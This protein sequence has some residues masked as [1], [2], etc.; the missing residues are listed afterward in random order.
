VTDLLAETLPKIPQLSHLSPIQLK[1]LENVAV[2]K[3][4]PAHN[5]L[6]DPRTASFYLV[7]IEAGYVEVLDRDGS[8]RR[9][10][11][12]GG[13]FAAQTRPNH[14]SLFGRSRTKLAFIL[15]RDIDRVLA[16][17]KPVPPSALQFLTGFLPQLFLFFALPALLAAAITLGLWQLPFWEPLPQSEWSFDFA[18]IP[19]A[20]GNYY[21]SHGK[22]ATAETFFR[23]S[24]KW[25]VA[26]SPARHALGVILYRQGLTDQAI[27]Q[28][29]QSVEHDPNALESYVNLGL[30]LTQQGRLAEAV[31]AMQ[32]A[33]R[34]NPNDPTLYRALGRLE[35]QQQHLVRARRAYL[36]ASRLD[37]SDAGTFYILGYLYLADRDYDRAISYFEQALALS[38]NSYLAE[39]GL[40]AAYF[41]RQPDL[42]L[43]HFQRA[44]SLYPADPVPFFYTGVIY[45]NQGQTRAAIDAFSQVIW[46]N[47]PAEWINR[48]EGH[49][50]R[51]YRQEREAGL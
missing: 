22:P 46:R 20:L 29:R 23:Q 27:A 1:V 3:T 24:L 42:A 30:A 11:Y 36:E 41:E 18:F 9:S 13:W 51:L 5:L 50:Q 48:A 17:G 26:Y 37:Q 49:I 6:L 25:N 2:K 8:V 35:L 34:L 39:Q 43:A 32:Q 10:L 33:I 47:A 44:V 38:P 16:A 28:W 31:L 7:V 21:V 4:F 45:E 19:Y 12:R 15:Q 14:L 40:G